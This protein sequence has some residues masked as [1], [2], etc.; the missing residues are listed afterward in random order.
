M[1]ASATDLFVVI[2]FVFY[3]FFCLF[4][5]FLFV[6]VLCLVSPS[7]VF[8]PKP[9]SLPKTIYLFAQAQSWPN[10][11]TVK[12]LF[13]GTGTSGLAPVVPLGP[14]SGTT[15]QGIKPVPGSTVL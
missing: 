11:K 15:A 10:F 7:L 13:N 6:F 1:V 12:I 8:L 5:L 3:V 2:V 9:P 14:I 4:W